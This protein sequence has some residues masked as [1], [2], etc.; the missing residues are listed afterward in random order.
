MTVNCAT[1]TPIG[2]RCH[3]VDEQKP[4]LLDSDTADIDGEGLVVIAFVEHI[5][6]SQQERL[7]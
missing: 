6:V 3:Y 1:A 7:E 5:N 4:H 2:S